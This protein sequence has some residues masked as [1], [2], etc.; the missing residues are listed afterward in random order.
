MYQALVHVL[1]E[2]RRSVKDGSSRHGHT[3]GRA[4]GG[5]ANGRG[6]RDGGLSNTTHGALKPTGDDFRLLLVMRYP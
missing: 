3:S 4:D 1:S 6:D 2:K 5:P